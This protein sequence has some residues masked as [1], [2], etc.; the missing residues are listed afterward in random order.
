MTPRTTL[1]DIMAQVHMNS[2]RLWQ[3]TKNLH[4]FRPD[5]VSAL[6]GR[7]RH[8]I[9]PL[10]KK[11]FATDRHRLRKNQ[12]SPMQSHWVY[13]THSRP[14]PCSG[15]VGQTTFY[16]FLVLFICFADFFLL[17]IFLFI[18]FLFV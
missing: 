8:R 11:P 4:K 14:G 1:P 12:F 18:V 10:T 9:L 17:F 15:V 16:D 2:Q 3:N 5:W 7:S 6:S 13:Q